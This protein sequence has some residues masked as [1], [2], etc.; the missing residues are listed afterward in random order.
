VIVNLRAMVIKVLILDDREDYLRA[1]DGALRKEFLVLR[2]QT[3]EQARQLLD[4][5]VR[6]VL[7]DVR[8]SEQDQDNR[9]GLRFLRWA[10]ERFPGTPML[11]MSAYTDFD[12][13]VEANNS[14]ADYF[15]KKP[16]DLN[17]LRAL[18]RQFGER[19][20][21]NASRGDVGPHKKDLGNN[22]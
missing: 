4:D 11:M 5:T 15:L 6:V 2:G 10:K 1:L 14:G 22:S 9:D 13:A 20:S 3:V 8:L 21:S 12:A 18:L 19:R 7:I 16:I 17:E